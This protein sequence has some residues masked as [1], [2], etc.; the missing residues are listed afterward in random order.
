[1]ETFS[2]DI[3]VSTHDDLKAGRTAIRIQGSQHTH[4]R[5]TVSADN[6]TEAACI[7]VQMGMISGYVTACHPRI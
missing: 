1:M 3:E 7:A 6:I 5:V 2:F 4:H